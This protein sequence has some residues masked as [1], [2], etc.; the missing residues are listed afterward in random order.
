MQGRGE[1]RRGEGGS[2]GHGSSI[3][4]KYIQVTSGKLCPLPPAEQ[5]ISD[6]TCLVPGTWYAPPPYVYGMY[7]MH[8]ALYESAPRRLSRPCPRRPVK[9]NIDAIFFG[10]APHSVHRPTADSA[11]ARTHRPP[12]C[13][14]ALS[15]PR[16][17]DLSVW[18]PHHRYPARWQ[19]ARAPS[20]W[21]TP[22]KV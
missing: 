9:L 21:W 3:S 15:R 16:P 17:F 20:L 10:V 4:A 5:S 6:A 11:R 12:S 8:Q 1:G 14:R 13:P 19:R 18:P 2:A 22:P 7:Y